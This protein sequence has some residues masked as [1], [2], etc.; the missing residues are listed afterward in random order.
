MCC[1]WATPGSRTANRSTVTEPGTGP[2]SPN[3]TTS[4]TTCGSPGSRRNSPT[5]WST[6]ASD[7]AACARR[8]RDWKAGAPRNKIVL[9]V[10]FYGHGWTGVTNQNHGLF[11]PSTGPAPSR[12]DAG[13]EDY[14]ALKDLVTAGTY[15]VYRD[16]TAGHAWIFDGTTF[17]TYDDP[18]EMR[19]KA[20]YINDRGLGG[21]MIW[22]LD[23]D[24]SDGELIS[25]L[26]DSLC[27]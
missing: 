12:F 23:G 3:G 14:K 26:H 8:N 5:G 11:Q 21:A 15:K 17:W 27:G 13:T 25:A 1:T 18:T 2:R 20:R 4:P 19:R 6:R 9:G 7:T 16:N 22:S 10:P 24:T